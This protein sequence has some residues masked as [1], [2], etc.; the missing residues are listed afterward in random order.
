VLIFITV[1]LL[2]FLASWYPAF[3]VH[4]KLDVSLL[5]SRE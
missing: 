2:G 4:R 5:R 1:I 3:T